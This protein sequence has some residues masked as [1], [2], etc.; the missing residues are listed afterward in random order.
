M[1]DDLTEQDDLTKHEGVLKQAPFIIEHQQEERGQGGTFRPTARLVLTDRVRTSGLW[2]ALTPEDAK[3][4]VFLLSFITPNGWCRPTLPE[5]AEAMGTSCPK[6]KGRLDRLVQGRWQGQPLA[7]LLA[8]PDGLDAYLPGRRLVDHEQ[9][10]EPENAQA[11]PLR[12]PGRGAV[13]AY[14]R[15]RYAKTRE[16]VERQIGEMM[17]WTPPDFAGDDPAVAEGKRQAFKA[18][19]DVGMPKEQALD[20]LARFDI[21]AVESQIRWLPKRSAKN[22][23]RF[24]AAAIEGGYDTPLALQ[25][26][27]A[28]GETDA[29]TPS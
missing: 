12:T 4:L 7:E 6:A 9:I 5:L 1:R 2:R 15:A 23:A 28:E 21:E 3:T 13:V 10:A 16:E 25:R 24:L 26:Q 8:R 18:M 27:P 22:P 17:G 14:S 11:A 29:K 20:L 19:T